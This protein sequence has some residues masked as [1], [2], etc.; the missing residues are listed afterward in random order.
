MAVAQVSHFARP[1]PGGEEAV[2]FILN[3]DIPSGEIASRYKDFYQTLD[4]YNPF[5]AN[6][7]GITPLHAA[8]M[9]LSLAWVNAVLE[10]VQDTAKLVNLRSK[11]G[12]TPIFM[13]CLTEEERSGYDFLVNNYRDPH[14]RL[15]I[16]L[17]KKLI[18]LGAHLNIADS[19][20]ISLVC[21]AMYYV[22]LTI[23]LLN[24]GLNPHAL[25]I[26][27]FEKGRDLTDLISVIEHVRETRNEILQLSRAQLLLLRSELMLQCARNY[28]SLLPREL[29]MELLEFS[30]SMVDLVEINTYFFACLFRP[31]NPDW[32]SELEKKT[33]VDRSRYLYDFREVDGILEELEKQLNDPPDEKVGLERINFKKLIRSKL[34]E[35]RSYYAEKIEF[36]NELGYEEVGATFGFTY[37]PPAAPADFP[38]PPAPPPPPEKSSYSPLLISCAVMISVLAIAI[39]LKK[40]KR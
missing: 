20:S 37:Q 38:V 28:L 7:E 13:L 40:K 18:G 3:Q 25:P 19:R 21:H 32:R 14:M 5:H 10:G 11:T 17:A 29:F 33:P 22:P 34:S 16:H 31:L 39:L 6:S 26:M 23:C 1:G 36:I 12:K 24:Q 4:H 2:R 8:A 27:S 9:K 15:R 35:I 30:D